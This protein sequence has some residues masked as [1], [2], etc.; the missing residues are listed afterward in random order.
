MH[1]NEQIESILSRKRQQRTNWIE[2]LVSKDNS[3]PLYCTLLYDSEQAPLTT[4]RARL[5]ELGIDIPEVYEKFDQE[6][7]DNILQGYGY[8]GIE[9]VNHTHLTSE[10]FLQYILKFIINDVIRDVPPD[11]NHSEYIDMH[12]IVGSCLNERT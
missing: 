12:S 1:S 2:A 3:D 5:E 11:S 6:L 9:F 10:E 4:D 7:L 8:L